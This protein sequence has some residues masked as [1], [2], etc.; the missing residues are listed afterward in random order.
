MNKHRATVRQVAA[1]SYLIMIDG[2]PIHQTADAS[3]A[4]LLAQRLQQL[5][6]DPRQLNAR[7]VR[8]AEGRYDVRADET[9]LLELSEEESPF[10][11]LQ[12]AVVADNLR[13]VLLRA[14]SQRQKPSEM[15]DVVPLIP[16]PHKTTTQPTTTVANPGN[17]SPEEHLPQLDTILQRMPTDQGTV[18][19]FSKR[20][21]RQ[22]VHAG[23]LIGEKVFD[24]SPIS[25]SLTWE[26]T[27][28]AVVKLLREPI[29]FLRIQGVIGAN[30]VR[31][32]YFRMDKG[33]PIPMLEVEGLTYEIDLDNDGNTEIV[34]VSGLPKLTIVYSWAEERFQEVNVNLTLKTKSA[35]LNPETNL[36]EVFPTIP[37]VGETVS[38]PESEKVIYK[39]EGDRLVKVPAAT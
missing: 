19:L 14:G 33:F 16:K 9:I 38:P 26:M 39:Y 20:S 22:Y 35:Q 1:D 7:V 36:I 25:N 10:A 6:H 8:V 29:P 13:D 21:D 17:P 37:D 27:T 28:A 31:N 4:R 23:L 2:H 32:L 3:A 5:F 15:P 18:I 24:L 12:A 34:L 11:R 30:N